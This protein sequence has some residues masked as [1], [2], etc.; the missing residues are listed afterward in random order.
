MERKEYN[1]WTNYETWNVALWLDNGE[2]D[3][4]VKEERVRQ[5]C[6]ENE[7]KSDAV[8]DV[9]QW[10][11]DYVDEMQENGQIVVVGMFADLLNAALSE[12]DYYEIAEHYVDEVWDDVKKEQAE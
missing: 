10:L 11:K 4:G 5:A 12:V 7:E 2:M 3:E 6:E 9:C 8:N 1:G